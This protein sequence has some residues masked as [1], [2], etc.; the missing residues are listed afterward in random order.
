MSRVEETAE[1]RVRGVEAGIVFIAVFFWE[2][3]RTESRS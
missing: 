3:W 2:L 1:V